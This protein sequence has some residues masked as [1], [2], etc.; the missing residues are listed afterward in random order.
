MNIY[1]TDSP[2]AP[3]DWT[4][5]VELEQ[6]IQTYQC[7][8]IVSRDGVVMCRL[9]VAVDGSDPKKAKLAVAEKAR[10]WVADYLRR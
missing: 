4:M 9:S 6:L 10:S 2:L 8:V 1:P 7:I 5:H 3:P